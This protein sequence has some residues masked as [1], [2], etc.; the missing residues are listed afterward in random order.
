MVCGPP[1]PLSE[2]TTAPVLNPVALGVKVT[3]IVHFALTASDDGQVSVS[4]KSP[5]AAM[6]IPVRATFCLFV[7]VISL[8]VLVVPTV[9]LK[10][11]RSAG[12]QLTVSSGLL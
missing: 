6:L 4:E 8:A 10:N 12:L 3:E 9:R 1:D 11:V 7:S 2:T 5:N